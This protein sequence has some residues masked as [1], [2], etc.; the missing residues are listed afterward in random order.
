[1]QVVNSNFIY[2]LLPALYI[3]RHIGFYALLVRGTENAENS[4]FKDILKPHEIWC[5]H[6]GRNSNSGFLVYDLVF[7][8]LVLAFQRHLL[9]PAS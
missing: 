6:G 8:C 5:Y 1:V 4:Y 7:T 9:P 2:R 3:D